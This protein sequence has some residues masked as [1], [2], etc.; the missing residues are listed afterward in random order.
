MTILNLLRRAVLG[1]SLIA[2]LLG[3]GP[4][5][6]APSDVALLREY[7]GVWETEATVTGPLGDLKDV[8]C[9]LEFV[10]GS[11]DKINFTGGCAWSLAT[12]TMTGTMVFV[13]ATGNYKSAMTTSV[14]F[15]G[16]AIGIRT[17]NSVRFDLLE[18]GGDE[19]ETNN[20]AASAFFIMANGGID[21][22]L[23]LELRNTGDRYVASAA[24]AR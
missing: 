21:I 19:E 20:M 13:E 12:I 10:E 5:L 15:T 22:G 16:R 11:G 23:S 14:G 6:A 24:F 3:A 17:G 4:A 1:G 7:L 8:M 2:G 9:R 18:V